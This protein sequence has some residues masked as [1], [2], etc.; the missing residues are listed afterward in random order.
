[1]S[2]FEISQIVPASFA[3][4]MNFPSEKS[5]S[6]IYVMESCF[7]KFSDNEDEVRSHLKQVLGHEVFGEHNFNLGFLWWSSSKNI[8]MCDF[9]GYDYQADWGANPT[10]H[11]WVM[12]DDSLNYQGRILMG[13]L[14]TG[15][16]KADKAI[17]VE[18]YYRETLPNLDAYAATPPINESFLQLGFDS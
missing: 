4:R 17:G 9:V 6:R 11:T 10:R 3:G 16:G 2:N 13:S 12:K 5:P 7:P 1:M 18:Q 15:C 8:P 14:E